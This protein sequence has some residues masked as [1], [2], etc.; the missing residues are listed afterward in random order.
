MAKVD[1]SVARRLKARTG[2]HA[3]AFHEERV[4]KVAL[5]ALEADEWH[6]HAIDKGQTMWEAEVIDPQSKFVLSHVQG[7]PDETLIR[8]L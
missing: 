8:R 2:D 6:G 3:Q 1:A 5:E 7:R 4:H